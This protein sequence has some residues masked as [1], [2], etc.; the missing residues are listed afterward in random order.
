MDLSPEINKNPQQSNLAYPLCP[1]SK[2]NTI[3]HSNSVRL[4]ERGWAAT[5]NEEQE[6]RRMWELTWASEPRSISTGAAAV[7]SIAWRRDETIS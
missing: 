7:A 3:W 4:L 1:L 6:K 5:P 2:T